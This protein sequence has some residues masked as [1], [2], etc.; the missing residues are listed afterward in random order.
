MTGI[1]H[2][3]TITLEMKHDMSTIFGSAGPRTNKI[4]AKMSCLIIITNI[5][6]MYAENCSASYN[7]MYRRMKL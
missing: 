6:I 2:G 5:I 7:T 1:T 4:T 3:K